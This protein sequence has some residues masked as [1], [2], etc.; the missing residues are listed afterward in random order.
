MIEE[1]FTEKVLDVSSKLLLCKFLHP[2]YVI[3]AFFHQRRCLKHLL[4]FP[5]GIGI[6]FSVS[7]GSMN[8][9]IT[10]YLMNILIKEF[11]M[12]KVIFFLFND[13]YIRWFASSPQGSFYFINNSYL[14]M[15]GILRIQQHTCISHML[16]IYYLE[17]KGKIE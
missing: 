4:D 11:K 8:A 14:K 2:W 3:Y 13:K 6:C 10:C 9:F 16:H 1:E 7:L 17:K 12:Y 5:D 15:K